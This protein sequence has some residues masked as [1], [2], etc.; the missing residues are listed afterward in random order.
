MSI[1]G[2]HGEYIWLPRWAYIYPR[3]KKTYIPKQIRFYIHPP[4]CTGFQKQE[5]LI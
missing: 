1:Y 2:Y 4:I 5:S 3:H